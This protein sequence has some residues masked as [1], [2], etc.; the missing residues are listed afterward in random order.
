[1]R[2]QAI[3]KSIKELKG[4]IVK[5]EN[6]IRDPKEQRPLHSNVCEKYINSAAMESIGGTIQYDYLNGL[7]AVSEQ[8]LS[9]LVNSLSALSAESLENLKHLTNTIDF[10]VKRQESVMQ[11]NKN[12]PAAITFSPKDNKTDTGLNDMLTEL[13]NLIDEIKKKAKSV[14]DHAAQSALN[15]DNTST[16]SVTTVTQSANVTRN[17]TFSGSATGNVLRIVGDYTMPSFAGSSYQ[18]PAAAAAASSGV[19]QTANS[20]RPG[21]VFF[22]PANS[23]ETAHTSTGTTTTTTFGNVTANKPG[24]VTA[25]VA[26]KNNCP[27]Q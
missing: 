4:S 3:M 8:V 10:M 14:S 19:F 27:M 2:N 25:A 12:N 9:P 15:T 20:P 7:L 23:R 17:V 18:M 26:G 5:L 11:L 13:S 22:Q 21:S 24:E 16:S 1:M 6:H